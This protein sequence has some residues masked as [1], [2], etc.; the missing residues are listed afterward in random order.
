IILCASPYSPSL[1]PSSVTMAQIF[2]VLFNP[3]GG[4]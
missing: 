4:E 1:S 3:N 2:V